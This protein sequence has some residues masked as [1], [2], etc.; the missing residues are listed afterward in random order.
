MAFYGL[1][2]NQQTTMPR[3]NFTITVQNDGA[4]TGRFKVYYTIDNIVQPLFTSESM[5]FI[6][7]K[8]SVEIPWY[9]QNIVVYLE[10]L[11]FS[12]S[13]FAE[14]TS[15]DTSIYCTKCYKMWGAVTS[16]RWDYVSC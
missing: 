12:W 8:K 6:N 3:C 9:S 15:I 4:F 16:P 1:V 2:T 10:R 7:Q 5:P 13:T 11:G 14:D